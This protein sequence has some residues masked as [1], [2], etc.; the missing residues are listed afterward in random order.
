MLVFP[1]AKINLGLY[2]TSRRTDGYHNLET[3][4]FP[5]PLKDALEILPDTETKTPEKV[6]FYASGIPVDCNSDKNLC[7]KAY[8]MLD[9]DF[10]LPPVKMYLHK[11]IPMGA[12]MGGGSADGAFTLTLLNK[13]F[14][15][16]ISIE[17]LMEYASRIGSDCAFFIRNTPMLGTGRGEILSPVTVNLSGYTLVLVKPSIHV[18]TAEAYKGVLLEKPQKPLAELIS[19]PIEDWKAAVF[20]NFERGIFRN[21]PEIASIKDKLY[22]L[23]AKFSLMSGSGSTVFGLFDTP[24]N[25]KQHFPGCFYWEGVV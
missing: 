13:L 9:A 7:V 19:N 20:N 17:K 14:G 3:L 5:V 1:N 11:I 2:V 10:N 6:S 22:A 25:G 12:G 18:S 8:T 24:L 23:G 21:H 16:G 15:L 4:F